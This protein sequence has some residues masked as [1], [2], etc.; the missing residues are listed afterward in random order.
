MLR[1]PK[2]AA[3]A[4]VIRTDTVL[5]V[6]RRNPPDEGLWGFPGG[7]VEL[8]ETAK[9]AAV[10]ELREETEVIAKPLDYITNLDVI[11][12]DAEGKIAHH[13]LLVAV[14]CE[15]ISGEPNA[16]D[17]VNDAKWQPLADIMSNA[18]LCSKNV[19]VVINMAS[20]AK[21]GQIYDHGRGEK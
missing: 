18:I 1:S 4:V 13:F 19:D 11:S 12:K 6:K 3:I 20:H 17:D 5:L 7:H 16:G 15:Y 14:L 2:L 9:E 21:A 10:R 8:G